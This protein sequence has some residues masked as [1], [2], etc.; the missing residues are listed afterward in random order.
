MLLTHLEGSQS[1]PVFGTEKKF[2]E[3]HILNKSDK[4]DETKPTP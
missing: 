3:I 4:N 1:K 2:P